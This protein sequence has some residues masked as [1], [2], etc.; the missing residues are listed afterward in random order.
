MFTGII[1]TTGLVSG[2]EAEGTNLTFRIESTL[3][4]EL[5]IDQ[6]SFAAIYFDAYNREK[7]C[8]H[9]PRREASLMVMSE[10]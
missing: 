7:P 6:S 8:Y 9:F 2:I 4:A 1:E 3:A 10:S 5:K